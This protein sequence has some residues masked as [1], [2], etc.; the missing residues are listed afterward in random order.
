MARQPD[1]GFAIFDDLSVNFVATGLRMGE[2][3]A[4]F[5]RTGPY[6]SDRS[7]HEMM[8]AM[9]NIP[10]GMEDRDGTRTNARFDDL[11]NAVT[12]IRGRAFMKMQLC[13]MGLPLHEPA[14]EPSD[15]V[16]ELCDCYLSDG[17]EQA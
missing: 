15:A 14:S 16:L 5:G 11:L 7:W 9:K 10:I 8:A 1:G 3:A 13:A 17:A 4:L 6:S 12:M 2:A